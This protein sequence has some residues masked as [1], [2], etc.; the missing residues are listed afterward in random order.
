M[1]G[2][3]RQKG[4]LSLGKGV[5][6]TDFVL[7]PQ[8]VTVYEEHLLTNPYTASLTRV[9]PVVCWDLVQQMGLET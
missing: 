7:N 1:C 9:T 4:L 6:A 5:L 3:V 8:E 2:L